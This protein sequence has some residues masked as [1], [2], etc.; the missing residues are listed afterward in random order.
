MG[1][2]DRNHHHHSPRACGCVYVVCACSLS[3]PSMWPA[4]LLL[5]LPFSGVLL[6][7]KKRAEGIEK[8]DENKDRMENIEKLQDNGE[9]CPQV[10]TAYTRKQHEK[11]P[12]A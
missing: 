6:V 10:T 7:E 2:F 9:T 1:A 8:G 3:S 12:H 11:G 5:A 4:P